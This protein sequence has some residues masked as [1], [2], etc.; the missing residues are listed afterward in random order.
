[1]RIPGH[2]TARC[3]PEKIKIGAQVGLLHMLLVQ[4]DVSSFFKFNRLFF[5]Q[6]SF[7]NYFIGKGNMQQTVG[8]IQRYQVPILNN[9]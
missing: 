8:Y 2:F 9:I 1:M 7:R 5:P 4:M 3:A 6:F